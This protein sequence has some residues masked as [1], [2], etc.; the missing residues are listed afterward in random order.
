MIQTERVARIE[1]LRELIKLLRSHVE[2]K[3]E[4]HMVDALE[5]V[6][7]LLERSR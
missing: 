5:L 3:H 6:V 2:H 1:R 4:P 7:D